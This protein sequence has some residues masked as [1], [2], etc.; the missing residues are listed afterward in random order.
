M[1]G[2]E[3]LPWRFLLP[4]SETPA[5]S[6]SVSPL[7]QPKFYNSQIES[8]SRGSCQSCHQEAQDRRLLSSVWGELFIYIFSFIKQFLKG[9]GSCWK[10]FLYPLCLNIC[11][12]CLP[13]TVESNEGV[14]SAELFCT[15][16]GARAVTGYR[17]QDGRPSWVFMLL[18]TRRS[19]GLVLCGS[20]TQG[21]WEAPEQLYPYPLESSARFTSVPP[22]SARSSGEREGIK[23]GF[24]LLVAEDTGV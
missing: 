1:Y 16:V 11:Q 10:H 5:P 6:S 23:H 22:A 20:G 8:G 4:T 9:S 13:E 2:A 14:G 3:R 7:Q 21:S 17:S 12:I 19:Q 15:R 18:A 24:C